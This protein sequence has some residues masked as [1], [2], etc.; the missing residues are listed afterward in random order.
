[1]QLIQNLNIKDQ[2]D[3]V[4]YFKLNNFKI[5]QFLIVIFNFDFSTFNCL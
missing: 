1:L 2:N 3:N 5:C 4:K